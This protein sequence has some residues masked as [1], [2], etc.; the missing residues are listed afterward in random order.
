MTNFPKV[1]NT[2]CHLCCCKTY[3]NIFILEE[4]N[5]HFCHNCFKQQQ[6]HQSC[7]ICKQIKINLSIS[8]ATGLIIIF[9][10]TVLWYC[11]YLFSIWSI[12]EFL[13]AFYY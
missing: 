13:L 4:C 11:L 1:S 2:I 9:F 12:K 8:I 10:P 7:L 6:M 3:N 5:H